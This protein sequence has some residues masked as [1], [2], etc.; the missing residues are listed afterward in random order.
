LGPLAARVF[1]RALRPAH[2]NNFIGSTPMTLR[3]GFARTLVCSATLALCIAPQALAQQKQKISYKA[4][5]EDS[6]YTQRHVIDAGDESGH[7]LVAFEIHRKFGTEAPSVN[8]SKLKETWSRGYGDYVNYNG[9]S[10]NYTT[11]VL[12]NGDKFFATTR[13]MGQADDA[14]KRTTVAVGEIRGGTGKLSGIKGIVRSK[15]ASDGKAGYNEQQSEIEY[16]LPN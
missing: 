12:E 4:G 5:A 8:G 14:G 7:Q 3:P 16:W 15:G 1:R 10:I 2:S 6:K 13:T 11:Y 9:L